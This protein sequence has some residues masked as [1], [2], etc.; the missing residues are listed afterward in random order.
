MYD[1]CPSSDYLY[2]KRVQSMTALGKMPSFVSGC[3]VAK[4]VRWN[5][6]N[7]N[8]FQIVELEILLN[9]L[10]KDPS[11]GTLPTCADMNSL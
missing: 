3:V 2:L 4:R 5:L 1:W 8:R 6:W 9:T 11:A 7:F 10:P